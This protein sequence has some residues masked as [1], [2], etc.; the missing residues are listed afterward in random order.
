[1]K[2][3]AV[4]PLFRALR[5]CPLPPADDTCHPSSVPGQCRAES[6]LIAVLTLGIFVTLSLD[7]TYFIS[8]LWIRV[9][10]IPV[11][12]FLLPHVF[13]MGIA[14]LIPPRGSIPSLR[15]AWVFL[16]LLTLYASL[17]LLCGPST[18]LAPVTC[19]L[20]LA[21][22]AANLLAWPLARINPPVTEKSP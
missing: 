12:T 18:D 2:S 8:S 1:M 10:L 16:L 6:L 5:I 13:M 15:Q 4:T 22:V 11:L 21:L 9:P 20:W 14:A 3:A 17:R 7:L 19:G